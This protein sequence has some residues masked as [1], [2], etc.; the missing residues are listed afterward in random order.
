MYLTFSLFHKTRRKKPHI[1]DNSAMNTDAI[2]DFDCI[3]KNTVA[4]VIAI[5]KMFLW[6][7]AYISQVSGMLMCVG[8][9]L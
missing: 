3:N 7:R 1:D 5:D 6:N 9:V 8:D 4:M 2:P